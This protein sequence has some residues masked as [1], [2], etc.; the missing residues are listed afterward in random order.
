[1]KTKEDCLT[2]EQYKSFQDFQLKL[3]K[4]VDQ[5]FPI[6]GVLGNELF[7]RLSNEAFEVFEKYKPKDANS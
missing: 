6:E 1:M 3:L 5:E 4:L 2:K 7:Q